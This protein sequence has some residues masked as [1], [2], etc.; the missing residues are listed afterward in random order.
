MGTRSTPDSFWKRVAIA[1]LDDCW[2]W[3]GAI[4]ERGYG[5]VRYQGKEWRA[6]ELALNLTSHEPCKIHPLHRCSDQ[7]CC[8]PAHLYRP[9][10][11][12]ERARYGEKNG[13]AVLDAKKVRDIRRRRK[14]ETAQSIADDMDISV[15]TVD[16]VAN[17]KTWRHLLC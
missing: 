7:S 4:H 6:H 17:G 9:R 5:R 16:D 1:G 8:N 14:L 11:K 3:L 2:P 13:R 15:R 12:Q 10:K